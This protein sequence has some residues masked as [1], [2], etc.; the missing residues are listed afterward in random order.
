MIQATCQHQKVQKNGK[1]PKGATRFRCCLCGKS[2][3]EDIAKLDGMRIGIDKAAKIVEMLCEGTSVSA[4]ARMMRTSKRVVLD[5]LVMFGDRCEKY[6]A[7]TIKGVFV[8]DV[9]IDEIWGYVLC[10]NATAKAQKMVGGCG[11]NYC[12]TALDRRSKLL[13]AWHTGRRNEQHTDQFIAKLDR[14][15]FGHFHISS[16]GWRS[17][18]TTIKKYLGHRVD[19]GVMTKIFAHNTAEEMRRYSPV[20]IIGASKTPMHGDV[21]QQD[22]ICTSHVE[23]MNGS[24]RTFCK[25]M[26]RLTYCFSKKWS[27]HRAAL[28]MFFAHYNFCRKHRSLN[29]MSPAMAHGISTEVWTV[30]QLLENVSK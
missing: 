9:Q 14:A 13:V 4:T 3:T 27:N 28:A 1:T 30:K 25:R 17:Y 5:V 6:M 16:D 19:H 20:K 23:R 2:W 22:R 12:F 7:E 18:P 10:K 15:T 21:Y 26:G 8:D 29:G 24:I 11:D